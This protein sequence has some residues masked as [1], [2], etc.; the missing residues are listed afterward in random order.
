MG[1]TLMPWGIQ[2][3]TSIIQLD[4]GLRSSVAR[5]AW[6]L[7]FRSYGISMPIRSVLVCSGWWGGLMIRCYR[8][9][10]NTYG[11]KGAPSI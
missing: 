8:R 5:P 10:G 2:A 7:G 4:I 11:V 1:Q 9:I 6:S 3:G